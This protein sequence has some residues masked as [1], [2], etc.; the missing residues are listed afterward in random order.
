[1]KRIATLL[2]LLLSGCGAGIDNAK[3]RV[4]VIEEKPRAISVVRAPLSPASAYVREAS[5]QGLVGFDEKGR[6]TPALSARWIVT[7]DGLSYIFRLKKTR[8]NDGR[9]VTSSD[10]SAALNERIAVLRKSRFGEELLPVNRAVP[11]TGKVV[12]IRLK[13]PMPNLLELLAQPEFGL[14]YRGAGSGPMRS[15]KLPS[16]LEMHRR[17]D[18][19]G[20]AVREDEAQVVIDNREPARALARFAAGES[21][22]LLGGRFEH[23]PLLAAT[24]GNQ[25]AV[26]DP[27]PGL[28]G[29]MVVDA[30]PFLSNADN[31]EAIAMAI[32]RPRMLSSF[33]IA[34]WREVLTLVPESMTN[35]AAVARP[36]W[37]RENMRNRK[38]AARAIILRWQ[39]TNGKVRPLR[40]AMPRGAGSRILFARLRSDFAAVGLDLERVTYT[41]PADLRLIDEVADL[42]SPSWYL[43]RLSCRATRICSEK[44]DALTEEARMESDREARKAKLGEAEAELQRTRNF[45]PIAN[46]LR[47]SLPKQGLLGFAPN[48]RG[49]HPLQYL[50]R[51]TT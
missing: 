39:A 43:G 31:R 50:G 13:A 46:P 49:F 21:D 3:L 44:A 16:G 48:P 45:I 24:E 7:D 18:E 22:L 33:N 51:G 25:M 37:T 36:D 30:G 35:R 41:Q 2:A 4:D 26:F 17:I 40:I 5:S 1:M 20:E 8:W 23:L 9:E 42:S 11:M 6:V 47:W 29:L 19:A 14:L 10:V 12:E 27:V 32:D 28:F 38:E 15:R 34:S